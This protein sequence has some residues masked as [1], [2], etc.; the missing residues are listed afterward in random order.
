MKQHIQEKAKVRQKG[1]KAGTVQKEKAMTRHRKATR[2]APSLAPTCHCCDRRM[3][4]MWWWTMSCA[5]SCLMS[6]LCRSLQTCE[7]TSLSDVFIRCPWT[8]CK[9]CLRTLKGSAQGIAISHVY[10][11]CR[12]EH[13]KLGSWCNVN[14]CHTGWHTHKAHAI[15]AHTQGT[16]NQSHELSM[17][18]RAEKAWLMM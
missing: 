2:L 18:K 10:C 15:M 17:Q 14:L 11:H 16:C 7:L 13:K 5:D 6:S 4:R 1:N 9:S 3:G 12:K 8:S